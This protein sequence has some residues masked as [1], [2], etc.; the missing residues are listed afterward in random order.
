VV[1]GSAAPGTKSA[2]PWGLRDLFDRESV[3]L[4]RTANA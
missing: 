4:S 3:R 1:E 2:A